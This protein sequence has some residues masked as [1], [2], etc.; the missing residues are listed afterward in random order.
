MKLSVVTITC[1]EAP[2][3][4][5][6]ARTISACLARTP[7]VTLQWLIVDEKGRSVLELTGMKSPALGDRMTIESFKPPM[8]EHRQGPDKAVAHNTAR[9]AGLFK[10]TGDYVVYLNDCNLV[11]MDWVAVARDCSIA[12]VGW[13]CKTDQ[14]MDMTVPADGIMKHR[15]HHDLLHPVPPA[16][17]AGACW[18]APR[19]A[20]EAIHGFDLSYDGQRKG[21]DH[22]AIL[23][24]ARTGLKFVT[25][26]RALTLQLRRTKIEQEITNRRDVTNGVR[27]QTLLND[28]KRDTH[29]ILPLVEARPP[30]SVAPVAAIVPSNGAGTPSVLLGAA[31]SGEHAA[32]P[33]TMTD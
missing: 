4:T 21:N 17:V 8:T 16:T 23:R 32:P 15:G 2:R 26:E 30:R 1:R 33:K 11:T 5:E 9:N 25:T 10:A 3:L 20:F 18:G 31:R 6:A 27:N 19:A 24:L 28:L 22:E 13:R 7:D 14:L 29:R 12:G